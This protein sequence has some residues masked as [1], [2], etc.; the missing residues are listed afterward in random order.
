MSSRNLRRISSEPRFSGGDSR[1]GGG[2]GSLASQA[3]SAPS[4]SSGRSSRQFAEAELNQRPSATAIVETSP[5]LLADED[6][7]TL[8]TTVVS[9]PTNVDAPSS[10][11]PSHRRGKT[12]VAAAQAPTQQ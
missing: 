7:P 11:L 5:F 2:T 10:V 3:P 12:F 9:T 8:A 4:S 6:F 1:S